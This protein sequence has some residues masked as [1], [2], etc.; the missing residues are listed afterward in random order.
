MG[1]RAFNERASGWWTLVSASLVL[2]TSIA[3]ATRGDS[4][5]YDIQSYAALQNGRTL[6][7]RFF[8]QP[9]DLSFLHIDEGSALGDC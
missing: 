3:P 1:R 2:A 4:I 9:S 8:P 6:N 5:V 7:G